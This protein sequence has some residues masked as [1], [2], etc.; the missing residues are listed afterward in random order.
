MVKTIQSNIMASRVLV[1]FYR[2]MGYELTI[3][4]L[5]CH[6]LGTAK[7][8]IEQLRINVNFKNPICINRNI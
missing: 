3:N 1:K 7:G 4:M 6:F 2:G 8:V 5:Q